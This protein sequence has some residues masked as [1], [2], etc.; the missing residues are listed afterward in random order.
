MVSSSA[1]TKKMLGFIA[2]DKTD[3]FLNNYARSV[4]ST[5]AK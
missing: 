2:F 4:E 3:V 1:L 5:V